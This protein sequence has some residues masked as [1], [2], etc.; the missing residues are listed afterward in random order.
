MVE[1]QIIDER[2]LNYD[3]RPRGARIVELILHDCLEQ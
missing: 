2:H 1:V 3:P